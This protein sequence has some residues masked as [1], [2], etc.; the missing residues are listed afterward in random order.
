MNS[1]KLHLTQSGV[2][3]SQMLQFQHTANIFNAIHQLF[4]ILFLVV[5]LRNSGCF[6][7]TALRGLDKLR[8]WTVGVQ[9]LEGSAVFDPPRP[10][11]VED[12]GQ[13]NTKNLE[14]FLGFFF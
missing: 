2:C 3:L 11:T 5:R 9:A 1:N 6:T 12:W 14:I 10:P 4:H 8:Y 13:R 7:P